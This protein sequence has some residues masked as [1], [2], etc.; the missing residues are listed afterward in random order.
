MMDDDERMDGERTKNGTKD[1]DEENANDND[2]GGDNNDE[3]DDEGD[4]Y[5][6]NNTNFLFLHVS[7]FRHNGCG[8]V[9]NNS[10]AGTTYMAAG[11]SK[12]GANVRKHVPLRKGPPSCTG[13]M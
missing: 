2:S 4:R 9:V 1:N 6:D 5:C 11:F 10:L 3:D 13:Q 8:N 12:H 7:S